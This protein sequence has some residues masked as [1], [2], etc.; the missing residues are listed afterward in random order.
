MLKQLIDIN[1]DIGYLADHGTLNLTGTPPAPGRPPMEEPA[2]NFRT[3]IS[4]NYALKSI[5][6]NDKNIPESFAKP[7]Y[8][9][10]Q[11]KIF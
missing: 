1:E 10:T 9:T 4:Q 5:T 3:L 6:L 2:T 11:G 7:D 8:R